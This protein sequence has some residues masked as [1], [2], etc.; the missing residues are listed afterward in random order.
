MVFEGELIGAFVTFGELIVVAVSSVEGLVNVTQEMD[1]QAKCIALGNVRVT[2]V[3]PVLNIV[4]DV[5][6]EVGGAV[7]LPEPS[8]NTCNGLRDIPSFSV[9]RTG[10]VGC[11][12]PS[13]IN[14]RKVD[15]VEVALPGTT[16]VFD[17]VSEGST[18][19]VGVHV[20]TVDK[21]RIK[22]L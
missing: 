7:L 21:F 8:D 17:I 12:L 19:D 11:S 4:V 13:L 22:F 9:S 2:R 16:V 10:I 15:K 6:V 18:L 5:R 1:E 20:L 14:E 3:E